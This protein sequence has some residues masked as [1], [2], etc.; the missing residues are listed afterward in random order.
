MHKVD[1]SLGFKYRD[2][3]PCF[4]DLNL[5]IPAKERFGLLGLM[6]QANHACIHDRFINYQE[7]SIKLLDKETV[8]HKNQ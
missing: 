2:T 5:E 7:G 1:R 4:T 8:H 3:S 6:A